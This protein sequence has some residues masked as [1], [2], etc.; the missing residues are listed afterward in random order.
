MSDKD[1]FKRAIKSS[2]L[3]KIAFFARKQIFEIFMDVTKPLPHETVVDIGVFGGSA[4]PNWNFLEQLYKYPEN[5]TAVGIE[6][7]SVLETQY[8]G[9]KFVKVIPGR[10]LPFK[11]SQFD[12]G[13][14]SATIEH[15]GS[16]RN[17]RF[18]LEEIIRVSC[19]A[20]I[21]T[22]NR[23]FPMEVHTRLPFLHW[24]PQPFF[25]NILKKM[26]LEFYSKEE[27]LNL[28][29]E[30]QF[31]NLVPKSRYS[32][33]LLYKYRIFGMVSNLILLIE[34]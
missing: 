8:P 1:Y 10:P 20:V 5:I 16:Y 23:F 9:L 21:I 3:D 34:K 15:V 24:L 14:C 26:G 2:L 17:Q 4:D 29:T 12:I 11:Q 32:K 7:A 33:V 27:N 6:D 28:L 25:R 22:P 19:R 13:F 31:L 30:K 18:F